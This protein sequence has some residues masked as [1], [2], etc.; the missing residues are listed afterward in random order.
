VGG[1]KTIVINNHQ[2]TLIKMSSLKNNTYIHTFAW[3]NNLIHTFKLK[4]SLITHVTIRMICFVLE[5]HK[6]YNIENTFVSTINTL[7]T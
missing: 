1:D 3:T 2:N 4:L 7:K 6:K 5:Q